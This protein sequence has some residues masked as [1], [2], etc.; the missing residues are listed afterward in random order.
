MVT[1]TWLLTPP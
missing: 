1:K